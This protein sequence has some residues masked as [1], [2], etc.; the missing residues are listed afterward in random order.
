M[1]IVD[2]RQIA[3][4]ILERLK[5]QVAKLGRT[6]KLAVVLVGDDKPSQT[7]VRNKQQAA[8]AVGIEFLLYKFPSKIKE[9]ALIRAVRAIQKQKLDGIIVQLPLPAGLDKKLILNELDPNLD[10]DCLSWVSLGK[11]V[12]RDNSLVPPSP[13]AVLEILKVHKVALK[14]KHIVL[15]GQGDL[16]GKPLANILMH[17]PVTVTTCNK[18]TKNLREITKQADILIS[19]TG[20]AGLIRADMIRPGAAVIDAGVSFVGGHMRG[21]VDFLPVSKKASL[22]TPVPGGVGPVTVAKL[23]ENTVKIAKEKNK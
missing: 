10:V 18:D 11:L 20:R 13:G 5:I 12:I 2:G 15:V 14:G 21:D 4:G 19:G 17:M 8:A 3:N 9:A 22:I 16:I 1:S 23:L 6:P 7:Y